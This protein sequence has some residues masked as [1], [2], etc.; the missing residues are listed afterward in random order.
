MLDMNLN[1]V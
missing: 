1:R